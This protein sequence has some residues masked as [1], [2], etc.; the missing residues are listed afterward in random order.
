MIKSQIE[1]TAIVGS[2]SKPNYD[3]PDHLLQPMWLRSR[4]SMIDNGL[5]Y[6][7]IA[8]NACRHCQLSTECLSGDV[9][10]KQ[11]LNAT[12][13]KICDERV[14]AFI[15][16]NPNAW[17]LN[18]GAG[19]DTRFY[20]LDNG[21]CHWIELDTSENLLWREKLFHKSERYRS[22]AGSVE[23]CSWLN[24]LAIP[25][26]AAV[27]VV[28]EHALLTKAESD[29]AHFI[30]M[31]SRCFNHCQACVVVAGD[32]ASTTLGK[33]LGSYHYSHGF[34]KPVDKFLQ[35]VPWCKYVKLFSPLDDRCGRWKVW[36][37]AVA[38]FPSLRNR[39]TP[40]VIEFS[41]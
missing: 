31:L 33:R 37:R 21:L 5:V 25:Q 18:I 38:A 8:A 15:E 34:N 3:V 19:L 20:R 36:Q 17:V 23:N 9:D 35:W 32:K 14:N 7:P 16:D 11:L 10:Q 39:L 4:E 24:N 41:W 40:A 22:I 26:N 30:Q 2:N 28:C 12:I 1:P 6:D 27:L 29:I 13:T